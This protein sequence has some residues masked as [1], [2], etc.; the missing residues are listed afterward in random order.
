MKVSSDWILH[1]LK[2][3]KSGSFKNFV[4]KFGVTGTLRNASRRLRQLKALI[5]GK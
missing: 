5:S 2:V 4:L 1:S 3:Y